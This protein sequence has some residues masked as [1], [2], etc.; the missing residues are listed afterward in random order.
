MSRKKTR[1]SEIQVGTLMKQVEDK[2]VEQTALEYSQNTTAKKAEEMAG[3]KSVDLVALENQIRTVKAK[4]DRLREKQE[5][6][7]G[8]KQLEKYQ[9]AKIILKG[10]KST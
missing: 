4:Y 8:K 6:D 5:T 1:A 3:A 7:E 10:I 2:G 9:D